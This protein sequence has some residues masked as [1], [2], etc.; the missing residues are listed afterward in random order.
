MILIA[1]AITFLFLDIFAKIRF[2]SLTSKFLGNFFVFFHFKIVIV[3]RDK[4]SVTQIFILYGYGKAPE[5]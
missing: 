3:M 4:E 5:A 1:V 2:I